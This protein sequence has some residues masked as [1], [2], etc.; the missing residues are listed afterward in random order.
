MQSLQKL[1]V[2]RLI[3]LL[4]IEISISGCASDCSIMTRDS[5]LLCDLQMLPVIAVAI[6]VA[7]AQHSAQSQRQSDS[8]HS[9]LE[10][11]RKKDRSAL[12]NCLLGCWV[13]LKDA[14]VEEKQKL[15]LQA[16]IDFLAF[17]KDELAPDDYLPMLIAHNI[18]S[19]RKSAGAIY[20]EDGSILRASALSRNKME[21]IKIVGTGDDLRYF[22]RES[23]LHVA[24]EF[25]ANISKQGV[26]NIEDRFSKCMS[27]ISGLNHPFL[28]GREQQ[29]SACALA[30][31]IV[32]DKSAPI[33][34][35]DAWNNTRAH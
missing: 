18:L 3:S 17:D 29:L 6:P 27:Y 5:S 16:A 4:L 30:Y 25:V 15:I 26:I 32:F 1:S 24:N 20:V 21:I 22:V 31:L 9:L 28:E 23:V 10:G 8:S 35:T 33:Q 13:I 11:L 12:R 34:L 19:I 14:A 2:I 7:I